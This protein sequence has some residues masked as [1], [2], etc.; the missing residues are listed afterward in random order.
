MARTPLIKANSIKLR[1]SLR[2]FL[3]LFCSGLMFVDFSYGQDRQY[4]RVINERGVTE[5]KSSL[6]PAEAKRGYAIVTL[7]G[8]IIKEVPAELSDEEFA[9]LSD[10]LKKRELIA[11]QEQEARDYNESLLLRYSTVNDLEAERQR[12]LSE[13]DV[14]I[15][16]LR[17]NMM[18]LKD[19]VERQQSRAA[20]IERTGREVPIFIGNNIAELE[21]KLKEADAS[22]KSMDNEKDKVD[23]RYALDIERF[24]QLVKKHIST[25]K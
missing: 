12:K 9:Q 20:N 17:S 19:Q 2:L 21:Q 10:E 11:Q 7:G 15:S 5:L 24:G 1:T 8:H 16:I 23:Q 18:S 13:F 4:Y 3:A 6:S 22:L 14:R 25:D